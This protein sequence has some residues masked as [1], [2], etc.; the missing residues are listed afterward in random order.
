[1][2][3]SKPPSSR[4]P[5]TG[6]GSSSGGAGG[7]RLPGST[8]PRGGSGGGL[9]QSMVLSP[10]SV[11]G[12]SRLPLT[13]SPA[14]PKFQPF[15]RPPASPS[16]ASTPAAAACTS[17]L[18]QLPGT[19][20]PTTAATAGGSVG[21]TA[22]VAGGA[23]GA[24]T[25]GKDAAMLLAPLPAGHEQQQVPPGS[26]PDATGPGGAGGTGAQPEAVAGTPEPVVRTGAAQPTSS[27]SL[28][29]Q[30]RLEAL[31]GEAAGLQGDKGGASTPELQAL[32]SAIL[33][34]CKTEAVGGADGAAIGAADRSR[35]S[36]SRGASGVAAACAAAAVCLVALA[37][38]MSWVVW[39][40]VDRQVIGP[41]A[42][43]A[44]SGGVMA[45]E[46]FYE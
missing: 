38:C 17:A 43:A 5:A 4:I 1:M 15:K 35:R 42:F 25:P 31:L 37:A 39:V 11:S 34:A 7:S 20:A 30:S 8:T 46:A 14:P 2:R 41:A 45:G 12:G 9:S 27:Q 40:L 16:P 6:S 44:G 21:D 10:S 29:L 13:P 3:P 18:P 19:A 36:P 32:A 26:E 28:S 24:Q 23:P 33:A 22:A